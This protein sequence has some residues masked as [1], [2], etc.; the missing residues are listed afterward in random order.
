M[1]RPELEVGGGGANPSVAFRE[2]KVRAVCCSHEGE[3]SRR[4]NSASLI[5][6]VAG[7]IMRYI[8]RPWSEAAL[9]QACRISPSLFRAFR[10]G[11]PRP[12]A[13]FGLS[14]PPPRRARGG[15]LSAELRR[16]ILS[17]MRGL[18]QNHRYR[19][20]SGEK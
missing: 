1:D 15:G 13:V 8:R 2:K 20:I 3:T 6:Y 7:V 4:Y 11:D 12:R 17:Y 18:T 14:F 16:R 10:G 9:S 5:N 19:R